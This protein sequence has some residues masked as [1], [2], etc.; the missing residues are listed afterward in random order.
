MLK[1][2]SYNI[3]VMST[4]YYPDMGAPS[5][6][7]DKYIQ[8]LKGKYNFYIITKTYVYNPNG[9]ID[10]PIFYISNWAHG[11]TIRCEK[12]ISEGRYVILSKLAL[13]GVKIYKFAVNQFSYPQ[14]NAWEIKE[15]LRTLEKLSREVKLDAII[16][17]SNTFFCQLA[18]LK[19]KNKYGDLKW[20]AFITDPFSENDIYYKYKTF[21]GYWKKRNR[22]SEDLIY[23]TADFLLFSEEMYKFAINDF[24]ISS[25]KAFNI[26]FALDDIRKGEL[27]NMIKHDG[28]AKLI[29][30]G[31][32]YQKIRN[33]EFMLSTISQVSDVKLDL[34]VGKGE[35]EDILNRY[36]SDKIERADFVS[37]E[38]YEKMIS[39]EYDFLV[40]VGNI[41]TLQAPSKMLELLSTGRPIL[42]F[43]YEE[44]S[45]FEMIE[46]YPL[47]LN[48]GYKEKDAVYKVE[49]FCRNMRGKCLTFDEVLALFPEH[50]L[51]KKVELMES[52]IEG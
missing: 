19:F 49:N 28:P 12:N 22:K 37:R 34:F 50:T 52:L 45:Q 15:N 36:I 43:Y 20:I 5:A 26:G 16:A 3:A 41:S 9:V 30:A 35:C 21:K 4:M 29:Y 51:D 47:G 46:K 2:G 33:P 13:L 25:Q 31:M 1:K 39:S 8:R 23:N 40:N 27:P 44:D 7:V 48:I 14:A 18:S 42:N 32:F 38:R 10:I 17:V 6:C 24:K 11:L